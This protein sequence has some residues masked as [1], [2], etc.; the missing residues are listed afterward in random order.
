[1]ALALRPAVLLIALASLLFLLAGALDTL[2]GCSP[3][4]ALGCNDIR[5]AAIESYAFGVVNLLVAV[6]I[7]RG[8]ERILAARIGLAAFFVVERP[9][10]AFALGSQAVDVVAVHLLTALVEA[11]ILVSTL[12]IWRL[13]HS[14]SAS[15][16]EMLAIGADALA[17]GPPVS[18]PA[19]DPGSGEPQA[20]SV[21]T[22]RP[23]RGTSPRTRGADAAVA[24]LA[25]LLALVL[26]AD[27]VAAAATAPGAVV[28][29]GSARWLGAVLGL[30][31]LAV[32]IPAVHGR[33][34]ALRLLLVLCLLAFVERIFT[35]FALKLYDMPTLLLHAAAALIALVLALASV[36]ALRVARRSAI[37]AA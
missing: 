6:L 1:M 14:V 3:A 17:A 15:D 20:A 4:G 24:R 7:A 16:L 34:F 23:V 13:G 30:V 5:Y 26:V 37:A 28:D 29:I 18:V 32:S 11:V 36:S 8:N 12:R 27:T 33:G 2:S 35:P 25:V 22:P 10:S 31:I 9:V 21:E 19:S